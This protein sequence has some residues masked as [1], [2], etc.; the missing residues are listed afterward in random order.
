MSAEEI[1]QKVQELI[2]SNS[3]YKNLFEAFSDGAHEDRGYW[4]V[5][6]RLTRV[7]SNERR[8]EIY[9]KFADLEGYL[10]RDHGLK[11]LLLPVL[12]QSIA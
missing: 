6:V 9:G 10:Q 5:P 2:S 1:V 4:F 8:Y 3:E 11:V 7:E 12:S